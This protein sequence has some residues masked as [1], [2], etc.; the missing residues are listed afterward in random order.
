MLFYDVSP[1]TISKGARYLLVHLLGL[2]HVP[3]S[4]REGI[5]RN[6]DR[7]G[8]DRLVEELNGRPDTEDEINP[9]RRFEQLQSNV[10]ALKREIAN[11]VTGNDV[12]SVAKRVSALLEHINAVTED[13]EMSQDT[14]IFSN[15][16]KEELEE[17]RMHLE[18]EMDRLMKELKDRFE[19]IK[20]SVGFLKSKAEG[21]C[22]EVADVQPADIEP[23]NELILVIGA[24][25]SNPFT[26]MERICR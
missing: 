10:E 21:F 9:Q 19:S 17:I 14:D 8:I 7:S 20:E 15:E 16:M 13:S 26:D 22:M 18:G 3:D 25:L 2:N 6:I 23:A 1:L 4:G 5:N 12:K 11:A 24:L